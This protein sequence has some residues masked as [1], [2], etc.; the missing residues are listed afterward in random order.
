MKRTRI[1]SLEKDLGAACET[2]AQGVKPQWRESL[3]LKSSR[4][5]NPFSKQEEWRTHPTYSEY[6][7]S[8]EGRVR[9][10]VD[11]GPSKAGKLLDGGLKKGGYREVILMHAGV[12][13]HK[14][15]HLLVL[16]AFV[17][18]RPEGCWGL[19]WDD[20][21]SNNALK[22]L[23]WGEYKENYVDWLRNGGSRRGSKSGKAKLTEAEAIKIKVMLLKGNA[24]HRKIAE[25]F[26][27]HRTCITSISRGKT[28]THI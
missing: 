6:D 7:V 13:H 19:H 20:D 10:N 3:Q 15:V 11:A 23:R 16:E 2:T 8:D 18:P 17:G 9:R 22:N 4:N 27:V 12:K 21:S 1:C 28:W 14:R 25:K 26:G 5:S 24:T